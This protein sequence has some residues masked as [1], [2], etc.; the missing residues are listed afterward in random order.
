MTSGEGIDK[1]A[2][3]PRSKFQTAFVLVL[4]ISVSALFLA[5]IWQFLKPLLLGAIFTGMLYPAYRRL[6]RWFRGREGLASAAMI[7][8]VLLLILGPLTAFLGIVVGQA[9]DIG[10]VAIPWVQEQ[11]KQGEIQKTIGKV[12]DRFPMLEN[13]MPERESLLTGA[14]SAAQNISG[15]L[16]RGATK[17]TTG[18]AVFFLNLFVMLYAMF[19]FFIHGKKILERIE[20]YTPLNSGEDRRM[21]ARF[22]SITRATLKGTVLIAVIQGLLGG[23]AFW[24]A[25]INGAAFWGTVMAVLSIIPGIGAVIVWLPAVVYL[26]VTGEVMK[27][28]LLGAWCAG[29]VSSVDNVLRPTLVGKEAQMPD[30]LILVGTLGGLVLFG[31]MGFIIGPIVCGLFLTAWEIYGVALRDYLPATGRS[32]ASAGPPSEG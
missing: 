21:L 32:E 2:A 14:A 30:L 9:A 27:G 19:F 8:L 4:V 23:L 10:E 6:V 12:T 7:V 5:M 15:Y 29:I 26:M 28:V 13:V 1:P 25:G 18:T 24:A 3:Q 31:P 20:Y 22:V 16:V 17:M 11:I